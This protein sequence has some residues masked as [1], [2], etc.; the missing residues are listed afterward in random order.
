MPECKHVHLEA[1]SFLVVQWGQQP[2]VVQVHRKDLQMI[3]LLYSNCMLSIDA[4]LTKDSLYCRRGSLPCSSIYANWLWAI[5]YTAVSINNWLQDVS[6]TKDF[7][8][9]YVLYN[10]L[11]A[12]DKGLRG[13]NILQSVVDWHCYVRTNCLHSI[14]LHTLYCELRLDPGGRQCIL[15]PLHYQEYFSW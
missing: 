15:L 12:A 2:P 10:A 1:Q 8:S 5:T 7:G 14:H 9:C 6:A 3:A 11:Y 4:D 13:Q